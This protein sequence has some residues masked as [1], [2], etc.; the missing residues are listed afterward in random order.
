MN[1]QT[2]CPWASKSAGSG[3]RLVELKGI[4]VCRHKCASAGAVVMPSLSLL[5]G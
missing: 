4:A 5:S 2:K 1:K 3:A